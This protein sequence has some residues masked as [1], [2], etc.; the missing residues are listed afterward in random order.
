V[1]GSA[2]SWASRLRSNSVNQPASGLGRSEGVGFREP[3]ISYAC[4]VIGLAE[5][6]R[7]TRPQRVDCTPPVNLNPLTLPP[8]APHARRGVL[9]KIDRLVIMKAKETLARQ[10]QQKPEQETEQ[11][12]PQARLTWEPSGWIKPPTKAQLMA[13]R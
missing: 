5:P 6:Q 7:A 1:R 10:A 8:V 11:N 3:S 2:A 13:G 12:Y 9:M 4:R